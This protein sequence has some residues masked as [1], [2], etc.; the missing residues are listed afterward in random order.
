MRFQK[1]PTTLTRLL[2]LAAIVALATAS[3]VADYDAGLALWKEGKYAESAKEWEAVVANAPDYAFGYFMLGNCFMKLGKY[4]DALAPFRKA[5]ELDPGQFR[6]HQGLAQ[7]LFKQKKYKEVVEVLDSAENVAQ[8]P[9]EKKLLLHLRGLAL[10]MISDYQRARSDL[11]QANPGKNHNVASSLAQACFRLD[12]Y[13]CLKD[14]AEKAVALKSNDETSLRLLVRGALDQARRAK[15][16]SEKSQHYGYAAQ[17][18]R[19]LVDISSDKNN[20]RELLAAA[21]LG[22]GSYTASIAESEKVLQAEPKNCSAMLN[23]VTCYQELEKWGS[24]VSWAEKASKCDPKSDVAF[25]KM[26]LGH[27]KLGKALDEK[28]FEGRAEHFAKAREAAQKALSIKNSS[29]AKEMAQIAEEAQKA[30]EN[31]KAV[32]LDEIAYKQKLAERAKAEE[33]ERRRRQEYL[34]RTGQGG[35]KKDDPGNE[36]SGGGGN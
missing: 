34:I 17:K 35:K 3:A 9:Q 33:E 7:A 27:N 31:N 14:A 29:F 19:Q 10:V 18:A 11:Q 13:T 28:A 24:V 6:H 23:I 26:A 22:A 25:A 5:V 15:S 4:G 12:D 20:A 36:G 21:L 1:R 8:Q 16:E 32:H 30:N 2:T